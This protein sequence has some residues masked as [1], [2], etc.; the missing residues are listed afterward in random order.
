MSER[1]AVCGYSGGACLVTHEVN[2]AEI[3]EIDDISTLKSV[4]LF[5]NMDE[6]EIKTVR[7][8]MHECR[9]APGQ[10]I[11]REGEPGDSFHVITKGKVE[12]MTSD[13]SG[14]ELILDEAGPGGFFGE[15]A[16]I[17]NETRS[18]D[19]EAKWDTDLYVLS[20][21]RFDEYARTDPTL[22]AVLFERLAKI[23]SS[24]LR[25]TNLALSD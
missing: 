4:P 5:S 14:K 16:F 25:D 10:V 7:G 24:R 15:L 17:D 2:M 20:R 1:R 18:A 23:I 19:V 8:I 21:R 6:T 22:G 11:I 13:G 12:F 9:F 3:T